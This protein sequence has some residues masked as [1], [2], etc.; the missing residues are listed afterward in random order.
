M[1]QCLYSAGSNQLAFLKNPQNASSQE[2]KPLAQSQTRGEN[3][4][5][6]A[7]VQK[8]VKKQKESLKK[9]EN[10]QTKSPW[11]YYDKI[12]K[13]V[14]FHLDHVNGAIAEEIGLRRDGRALDVLLLTS[15]AKRER[16]Y[17]GASTERES[18][19]HSRIKRAA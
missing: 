4:K 16:D 14:R 9:R 17:I 7:I 13:F 2:R 1:P 18:H 10:Q 8:Q 6:V 19:Q 5:K 3:N 12:K 11:D 15:E